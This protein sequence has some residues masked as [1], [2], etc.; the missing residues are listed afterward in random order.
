MIV[1]ERE[2]RELRWVWME[3]SGYRIGRRG[4]DGERNVGGKR[5]T[6]QDRICEV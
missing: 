3:G 6:G 2:C 4:W 1:N 5:A